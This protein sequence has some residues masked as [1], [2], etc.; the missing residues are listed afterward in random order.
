MSQRAP[1][2]HPIKMILSMLIKVSLVIALGVPVIAVVIFEIVLNASA[3]FN[4]SN[5]RLPLL[6]DKRLRKAI[7]TQTCIA[8]ITLSL[9]KKHTQTLVSSYRLMG[10]LV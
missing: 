6:F 2:F 5:A 9:L 10:Y 1:A 8:S 7:V 4:H 3:M